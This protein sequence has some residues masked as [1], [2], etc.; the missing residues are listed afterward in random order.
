MAGWL[1]CSLVQL[2]GFII[3]AFSL[4]SL[5]RLPHAKL[6]FPLWA[7][8]TEVAVPSPGAVR[9]SPGV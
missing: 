3:P 2:T 7:S 8:H 5:L 6:R 4:V 9:P 1:A